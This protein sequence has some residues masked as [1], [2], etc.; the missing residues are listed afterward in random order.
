M[1]LVRILGY[2]RPEGHTVQS[3]EAYLKLRRRGEAELRYKNPGERCCQREVLEKSCKKWV[4]MGMC[5]GNY[6]Q[7]DFAI[8]I[9]PL[10][11]LYTSTIYS[12]RQ[13]MDIYIYG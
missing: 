3:E 8:N 7:K 2:T 13:N 6:F 9:M 1:F 10:T 5:F 11:G 4:F 12:Y